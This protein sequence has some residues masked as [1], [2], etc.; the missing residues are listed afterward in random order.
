[1]YKESRAEERGRG[2]PGAVLWLCRAHA[3]QVGLWVK[4]SFLPHESLEEVVKLATSGS[5]SSTDENNKSAHQLGL[6][7]ERAS[8][9]ICHCVDCSC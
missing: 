5:I 1:M 6:T 9:K 2:A 7:F 3:Q 4:E 8:E